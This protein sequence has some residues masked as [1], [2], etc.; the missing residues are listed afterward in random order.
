MTQL[1]QIDISEIDLVPMSIVNDIGILFIWG[2]HL[3]RAI[4]NDSV[5][6]VQ[7]LFSCGLI[8]ELIDNELFP[9]SWISDYKLDGYEFIIEHDKIDNVSYPYEWTFSMLKDAALAVLN[10]NVIAKKYGYETKDCHSFNI[11]F[12]G[13]KPKFVDLGSFVKVDSDT[14]NWMAYEQFLKSYYYPLKIWSK[15]NSFIA[16]SIV[17]N[18]SEFINH[19]EFLLYKRPFLRNLSLSTIRKFESKYFKYKNIPNVQYTSLRKRLP[20]VVASFIWF[21]KEKN[22]LPFASVKFESLKKKIERIHYKRTK[23]RWGNY[24]NE[25]NTEKGEIKSTTR[26]DQVIEIINKNKIK[27]VVELGGNQGVLSK[28]LLESCN[29]ERVACTDYDEDAVDTMYLSSK[30]NN[31]ELLSPVLLNFVL[32]V[33]VSKGKPAYE[34]FKSDMV[35]ALAITHHLV[36][37]QKLRI[38][39]IFNEISK[40]SNKYVLIEFMPLGLWDGDVSSDIP[41]WYTIDWFKKS[42]QNFFK[43]LKEEKLEKNRI[44]FVGEII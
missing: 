37:S 41:E 4:E 20:R 23:S 2:N 24:H 36:L 29:L 26:F 7:N 40:Y 25:F 27:S 44:L 42:F 17:A 19:D 11:V 35:I 30:N 33:T 34:R 43:I 13:L 39:V 22:A 28:L 32:P 18:E 9:D 14:T 10:V 1:K 12:D 31:I 8:K 16:R 21:L 3:L 5:N 38:D 15:G 6:D